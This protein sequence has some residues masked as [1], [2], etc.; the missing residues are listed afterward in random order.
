MV[1]S[2]ARAW[3]LPYRAAMKSE[4][5]VMFWLFAT[6]MTLEISGWPKRSTSV[7]PI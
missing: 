7:G 1:T 2:A 5:E 6:V 3:L 4:I